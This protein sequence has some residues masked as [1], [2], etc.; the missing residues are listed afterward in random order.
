MRKQNSENGEQCGG[1]HRATASS[2]EAAPD[3]LCIASSKSQCLMMRYRDHR[4]RQYNKQKNRADIAYSKQTN[5]TD[6]ATAPSKLTL[7]P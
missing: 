4:A 7:F 2:S 3:M 6:I 1:A 5:T